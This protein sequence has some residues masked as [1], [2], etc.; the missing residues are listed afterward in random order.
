MK[1]FLCKVQE[2][3]EPAKLVEMYK[4]TMVKTGIQA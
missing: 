4:D 1:Y 2:K 3:K